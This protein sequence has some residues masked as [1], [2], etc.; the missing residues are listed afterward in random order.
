MGPGP[1]IQAEGRV[2]PAGRLEVADDLAR[3]D[4]PVRTVYLCRNHDPV[5]PLVDAHYAMMQE[6]RSDQ[7]RRSGLVG[8]GGRS[9]LLQEDRSPPS[10]AGAEVEPDDRREDMFRAEA[11]EMDPGWDE[12]VDPARRHEEHQAIQDQDDEEARGRHREERTYVLD[13]SGRPVTPVS[14]P[15]HHGIHRHAQEESTDEKERH[16]TRVLV[17]RGGTGARPRRL[18]RR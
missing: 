13:E 6:D 10:G 5:P 1:R 4:R 16:H 3:R 11:P 18:T 7:V 15:G 12:L 2:V 8:I 14:P 17:E 9:R